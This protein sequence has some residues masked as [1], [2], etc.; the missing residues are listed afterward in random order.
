M[1]T[2]VT[3]IPG[4]SRIVAL[5]DRFIVDMGAYIR[6]H[7]VV[8]PELTAALLPGPY[9]VA[10]AAGLGTMILFIALIVLVAMTL[11][12]RGA[13][14]HQYVD[15]VVSEREA[16]ARERFRRGLR[17]LDETCRTSFG[18]RFAALE[19]GAQDELLERYFSLAREEGDSL[20]SFLEA[21]K[22]LTVEGYYRSEAGMREELGFDGN[23]F[24]TEF[25]GCTHEE[26]RRWKPGG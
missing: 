18:T 13:L 23:A 11:G 8:V 9:R 25:E 4:N 22:Q 17:Q 14:V 19:T 21:F 24:V 5:A 26:H 20:A 3:R 7:G 10:A 15:F 2:S 16:P 12:A 6:T 1:P